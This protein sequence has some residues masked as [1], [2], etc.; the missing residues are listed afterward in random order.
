[1]PNIDLDDDMFSTLKEM[2]RSPDKDNIKLAF[3]IINNVN[4]YN[5][6]NHFYLNEL[7]RIFVFEKGHSFQEWILL[8][9]GK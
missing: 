8:R 1:M 4:I 5:E 2:I 3:D 6:K 9:N 7:N